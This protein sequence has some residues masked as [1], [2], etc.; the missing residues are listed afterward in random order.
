MKYKKYFKR[1]LTKRFP[2]LCDSIILNADKRY[3][4]ISKDTDFSK[5][6]SNPLDKRLDLMAYFLATIQ[7]LQ[8]QQLDFQSIEKVCTEIATEYVRPKNTLQKWFKKLP[9][10][11]INTKLSS[12][13]LKMMYKK[14]NTKGHQDGF[15]AKVVTDKKDTYGFGYGIDILE[16]GICKLFDKHRAGKYTPIL[17]E[18]DKITS[19][20]AGIELVRKG[21]I[22][23]GADKCDFRF[24]KK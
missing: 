17:C 9:P 2:E 8:E 21:T 24:K 12:L 20:L 16:C 15:L 10:K 13:F 6:S 19:N 11:L 5:S 14:I 18:V 7:S 1:I 23:N 3:F 4:Q 22:A